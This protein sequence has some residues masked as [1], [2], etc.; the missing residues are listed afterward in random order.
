MRI[1]VLVDAIIVGSVSIRRIELVFTT[2]YY[3]RLE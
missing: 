3:F 2:F 1:T